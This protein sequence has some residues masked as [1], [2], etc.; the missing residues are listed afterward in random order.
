MLIVQMMAVLIHTLNIIFDFA[1]TSIKSS[2]TPVRYEKHR[3][4]DKIDVSLS[5]PRALKTKAM[6]VSLCKDFHLCNVIGVIAY[7]SGIILSIVGF[8]NIRRSVVSVIHFCFYRR[9]I[10]LPSPIFLS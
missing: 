7:I 1:N 6:A 3:Q 10:E 5:P 9:F 8:G 4:A 2:T